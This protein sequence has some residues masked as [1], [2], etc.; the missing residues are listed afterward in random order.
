MKCLYSNADMTKPDQIEAMFAMTKEK[1]GPVDVLVNNAGVQHVSPVEDFPVEKWNLIINLNLN[2][3]FH[4]TRLAFPDMKKAGVGPHHQHRVGPRARR[5]R[6]S[7]AAYVAAKHGILG[8]TKSTAL[9]GATFGIRV[10]AI[11]PGYVKTPL[12][13]GPD[14]RSGPRARHHAGRRH[15]GRDPRSPAHQGIREGLGRGRDGRVPDIRRRQPDQRRSA[16]DRRRLGGA[17]VN[18]SP[19]LAASGRGQGEV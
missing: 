12:V 16:L 1:L 17:I 4:T 11:C 18:V 2:A 7:R 5:A 10:N 13:E 14:R 9:E 19:V 6:R 15:P 8:F 3:A